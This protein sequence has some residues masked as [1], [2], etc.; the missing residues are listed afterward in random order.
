LSFFESGEFEEALFN[1][2]KAISLDQTPVHY[3]NRGLAYYHFDK[4]LE[5]KEDFDKAIELD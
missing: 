1:Y 5:A 2:G 4:L 3:N